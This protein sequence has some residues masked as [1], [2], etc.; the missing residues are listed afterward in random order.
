[1]IEFDQRLE[2]AQMMGVA[3]RVARP[4]EGAIGFEAVMVRDAGNG[5]T[6]V[7]AIDPVASMQA[8]NNPALKEAACVVR[9]PSSTALW[10]SSECGVPVFGVPQSS[11]ISAP[12]W[13]CQPRFD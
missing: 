1:M 12:S 13:R 5:Q 11:T 8:I 2:F 4:F 9:A 6:E 10:L 3:E 7:A